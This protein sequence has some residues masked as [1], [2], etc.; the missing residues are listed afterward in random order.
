MGRT[1]ADFAHLTWDG[2]LVCNL[3][4]VTIGNI[5]GGAIVVGAVYWYLYS[6]PKLAAE[7]PTRRPWTL[8]NG[9][10]QATEDAQRE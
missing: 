9:A 6:R 4:P 2:F 10:P 7:G 3:L 5:I 8:R 1:L